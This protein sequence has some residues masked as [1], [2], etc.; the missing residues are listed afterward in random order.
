MRPINLEI[1]S[2]GSLEGPV[3]D[4]PQRRDDRIFDATYVRNIGALPIDELRTRRAECAEAEAELS[5]ARRL[6]QGKLD[7]LGHEL[8]RR[9]EGG[10]SDLESLISKLPGILADEGAP[11]AL[12]RHTTVVMPKNFEKQRRGIDRLASDS[13]LSMLDSL[14]S[15]EV[16][17]IVERLTDAES[18]T[19][20]DRKRVQYVIE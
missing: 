5:Y 15:G 13:T 19:S 1:K 7:I 11:S 17:E 12:Q 2:S 10:D 8:K 16:T 18:R 4:K 6:L 14:S 9:A 20:Q 3:S